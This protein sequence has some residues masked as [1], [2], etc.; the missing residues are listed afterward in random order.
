METRHTRSARMNRS[1]GADKTPDEWDAHLGS[2]ATHSLC[3]ECHE[4]RDEVVEFGHKGWDNEPNYA[5][6]ARCLLE[7]MM[8]IE[9]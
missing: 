1:C 5:V 2:S 9:P 6:C 3:N 4:F 8:L 7:A